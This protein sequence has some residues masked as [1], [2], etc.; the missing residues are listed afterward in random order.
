MLANLQPA[1]AKLIPSK[2]GSMC[3]CV[4]THLYSIM[5]TMINLQTQ[6]SQWYFERLWNPGALHNSCCPEIHVPSDDMRL[7]KC[8]VTACFH[9]ATHLAC[10]SFCH[11]WLQFTIQTTEQ[12]YMLHNSNCPKT[13]CLISKQLHLQR[14]PQCWNCPQTNCHRHSWHVWSRMWGWTT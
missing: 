12:F 4:S 13:A 5:L 3:C 9:A 6:M 7:P 1:L 10:H 11:I 14:L 2:L 8:W